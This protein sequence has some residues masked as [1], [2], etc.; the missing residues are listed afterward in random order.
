MGFRLPLINFNQ[1]VVFI[2]FSIEPNLETMLSTK[3]L[4][5]LTF[6]VGQ[7]NQFIRAQWSNVCLFYKRFS[8]VGCT[9]V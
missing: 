8:I 9:C 1:L 4:I 7:I 3:H 2:N 6:K 5:E